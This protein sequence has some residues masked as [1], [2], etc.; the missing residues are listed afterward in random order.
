MG[1]Y[2]EISLNKR[3]SLLLIFLFI[4]IIVL[5]GY[6]FGLIFFN[7]VVGLAIAFIISII[8]TLIS[9]FSGDKIILKVMNAKEAKKPEHTRLINIVEG[10]SI[11]AGIP[12]PKVYVIEEDSPNAFATGI[13]HEKSSVT[14]TTG[15]LKLMNKNELEGVIAHEISHIKNYDIRFMLLV[16]TLV[17]ISVLISD[18]ILR[19]LWW[20][21]YSH[22][23][24][25]SR[26]SIYIIVIGLVLAILTPIIVQLIK[27]A[28]SRKREFLADASGALLTRY[29]KGLA[30]ALRKIKADKEPMVKGANRAMAHLFIADPM[31]AVGENVKHWFSTHPDI[32]ARIRRLENM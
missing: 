22:R 1:I 6:V 18:M 15:L 24:R 20:G 4:I 25:D 21:G 3:K 14:V 19:S 5:L 12:V 2:E 17:G 30:D 10:L 16:A 28:V 27:L 11:A 23:G 9:I 13:N 8:F 29:P 32:N 7:P 26:G 31:R